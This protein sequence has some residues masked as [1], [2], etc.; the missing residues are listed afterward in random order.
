MTGVA[1]GLAKASNWAICNGEVSLSQIL[2]GVLKRWITGWWRARSAETMAM[3][4]VRLGGSIGGGF[5]EMCCGTLRLLDRRREEEEGKGGGAEK[6]TGRRNS[7][8]KR[9][10]GRK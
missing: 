7:G 5:T 9:P 1:A 10:P 4:P 3:D 8:R 6:K 2:A